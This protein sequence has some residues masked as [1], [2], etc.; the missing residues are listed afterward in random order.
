MSTPSSDP[1]SGSDEARRLGVGERELAIATHAAQSAA[2]RMHRADAAF[3]AMLLLN[4]YRPVPDPEM[5]SR[6]RSAWP[7]MELQ[8]DPGETDEE[9]A[10]RM[11][12]FR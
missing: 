7:A 5:P 2:P 8:R 4:G 12:L 1:G 9:Y 6:P 10:A 3:W 11:N